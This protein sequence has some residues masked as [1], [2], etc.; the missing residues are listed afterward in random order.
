MLEGISEYQAI[1]HAIT[2]SCSS[3]FA[4]K[5][6]LAMLLARRR[7]LRVICAP[8]HFGKSV[9]AYQYAHEVF[10][11]DTVCWINA[12]EPVFLVSLDA[13]RT[14]ED[15]MDVTP[16][17]KNASASKLFII[18]G[19]P[20]LDAIRF[21][22]LCAVI[23][24]TLNAGDEVILTTKDTRWTKLKKPYP[25]VVDAQLLLLG[26]QEQDEEARWTQGG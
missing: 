1:Q 21:S 2:E 8:A 9:L 13:L 19:C 22:T 7:S 14:K 26:K 25:E 17:G 10:A 3:L 15:Q 18:D 4:R 5:H 11:D 23:E 24:A 6:L 12:S 20:T 16:L